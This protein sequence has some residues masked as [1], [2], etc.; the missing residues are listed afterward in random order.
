MSLQT[1]FYFNPGQVQLILWL[2]RK[3]Y[4]TAPTR[5]AQSILATTR[6][7]GMKYRNKYLSDARNFR[8]DIAIVSFCWFCRACQFCNAPSSG[9]HVLH[10][11]TCFPLRSGRLQCLTWLAMEHGSKCNCSSNE[12]GKKHLAS[13]FEGVERSQPS[14]VYVLQPIR[15]LFCLFI[16]YPS[17]LI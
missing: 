2:Q 12:E 11:H 5:A 10:C 7:R 14:L 4:P 13:F 15:R 1:N 3:P 16:L 8:T 9:I 6:F 17:C